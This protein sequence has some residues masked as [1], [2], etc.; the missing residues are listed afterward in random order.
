MVVNNADRKGGHVIVDADDHVWGVDHGVTFHTEPKLRT[1]MWHFAGMPM[2]EDLQADVAS[3]GEGLEHLD[4]AT[5]SLRDLLTAPEVAAL[6]QR[7]GRVS[8][9]VLFP[10]PTGER[11][12]PWPML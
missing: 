11:P 6:A 7:A 3:L 9:T 4:P 12:F 10:E 2:P 5:Q 8:R 1:V